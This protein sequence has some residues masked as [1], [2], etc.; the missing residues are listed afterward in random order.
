MEL[1]PPALKRILRTDDLQ[2]TYAGEPPDP[3][4]TA[5]G[6]RVGG[7]RESAEES[8]WSREQD[9][10]IALADGVRYRIE[11]RLGGSGPVAGLESAGG[12]RL[13]MTL[14]IQ[15]AG[16]IWLRVLPKGRAVTQIEVGSDVAETL[17]ISGNRPLWLRI[18]AAV[19][20]AGTDRID[21]AIHP[22]SGSFRVLDVVLKVQRPVQ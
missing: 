10:V 9:V 11:G 22:E 14:P 7:A 2:D 12:V 6:V 13:Q 16:Q 8:S 17:E 5:M 21:L 19:E 4:G 20:G 18:P 3:D 1:T 15:V